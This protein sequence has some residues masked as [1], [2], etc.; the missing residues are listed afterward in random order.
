MRKMVEIGRAE[1][2]YVVETFVPVKKKG[3]KED[4]DMPVPSYEYDGGCEKKY[5]AKDIAE[6]ISIASTLLPMLDDEFSS[7]DEFDMAFKKA[8]GSAA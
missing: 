8:A 4:G 6:A 1:N 2:G 3:G 5:V 7:T